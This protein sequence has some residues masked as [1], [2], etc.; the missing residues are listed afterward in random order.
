MNRNNRNA[1]DVHFDDS[2]WKRVRAQVNSRT[3]DWR[4]AARRI[5]AEMRV[6]VDSVFARNSQGGSH[7]GITWD[8]FADQYTR[9]TDGAVVPAWGGVQ[10]LRGDGVVL[11][12]LR[13]SGQ[14]VSL[15]DAIGQDTVHLRRAAMLSR[16]LDKS[17]LVMGTPV[18]YA[19]YFSRLRPFAEFHLPTDLRM[20]R[21][22]IIDHFENG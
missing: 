13:P 12:R 1:L 3:T 18:V 21:R 7:R 2:D 19:E 8:Y 14:R 6:R 22:I 10:K 15:G 5:H 4:P 11:G 16:R 20:M 9:K 17:R